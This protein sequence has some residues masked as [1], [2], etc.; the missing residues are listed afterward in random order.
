MTGAH[1][2]GGL[3]GSGERKMVFGEAMQQLMERRG[4]HLTL[5]ESKQFVRSLLRLV[6]IGALV[7]AESPAAH[8]EPTEGNDDVGVNAPTEYLSASPAHYPDV[9]SANSSPSKTGSPL[10]Y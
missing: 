3:D 6:E 5:D 2:D 7:A 4:C 8:A 10:S 1:P 9:E